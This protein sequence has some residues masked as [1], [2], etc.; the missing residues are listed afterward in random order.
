[1][2]VAK[3]KDKVKERRN[4]SKAEVDVLIAKAKAE[5]LEKKEKMEIEHEAKITQLIAMGFE[6]KQVIKVLTSENWN[7][8]NA[9]NVLLGGQGITT[10]GGQGTMYNNGLPKPQ[11]LGGFNT[12]SSYSSTSH[13]NSN[14]INTKSGQPGTVG[15]DN[16]ASDVVFE[17]PSCEVD[18][19]IFC[20][21]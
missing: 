15:F 13:Y 7:V 12:P 5:A 11:V 8:E 10:I 21:V 20:F 3:A 18:S 4:L 14:A 1:M 16:T 6:R 2:E 17:T 19:M 9:V